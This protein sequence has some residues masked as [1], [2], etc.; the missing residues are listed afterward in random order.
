MR[1]N[2]CF[3]GHMAKKFS[4]RLVCVDFLNILA[5]ILSSSEVESEK[6]KRAVMNLF[7]S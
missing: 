7:Q 6:E 2:F 5:V 3:G 4:M 1:A